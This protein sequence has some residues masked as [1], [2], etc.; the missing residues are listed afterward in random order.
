MFFNQMIISLK[1]LI[2]QRI[3]LSLLE[4]HMLFYVVKMLSKKI[5]LSLILM[6][7]ME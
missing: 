5:L 3:E 7:F 6:I 4:L 2:F 1:I